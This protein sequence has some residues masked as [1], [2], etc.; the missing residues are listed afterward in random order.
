[1][2]DDNLPRG[3]V[4]LIAGEL[5][6]AVMAAIVK[7]LS[8]QGL[9]SELLVFCRNA[10]GMLVLMPILLRTGGLGQIR[11]R[12]IR[13]HLI[14]ASTG[15]AAMF[16]FFYTIAHI[17]LAEAVLVKM[18]APFFLPIIAFLWLGDRI[19][20]RTWIAIF[21]GFLGVALILRPGEGFNPV[22]LIALL[23]AALM[24]VAKVSIRRMAATEPPRRVVFWFG[25]FSTMISAAPLPWV[26]VWPDSTQWLWLLAIGVVATVAQICMTTAYQLASP[27]RVGV[28]NYTSVIWAASLG[29][30]FWGESLH[31]T[32]L[33]GTVLIVGAGV[34][35][36]R[37]QNPPRAAQ[38][39]NTST[40]S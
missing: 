20:V 25:A 3:A 36:L 34:W 11:T 12:H 9:P 1:M 5:L 27:G 2:P 18:T 7:H 6:L 28:Y 8:L 19:S 39:E 10:I 26:D 29:W 33:A 38:G 14:R 17:P 4:L 13:L 23:S 30:L 15:V 32:T 37:R 21:V 35:N 40:D 24:G 22:L 16:C 31:W